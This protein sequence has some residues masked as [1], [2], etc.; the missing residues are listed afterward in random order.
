MKDVAVEL[1][2]IAESM[3]ICFEDEHYDPFGYSF[4]GPFEEVIIGFLKSIH[5][6]YRDNFLKVINDEF[7]KLIERE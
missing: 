3:E 5:P 6:G 4:I 1:K 7:K 2:Y